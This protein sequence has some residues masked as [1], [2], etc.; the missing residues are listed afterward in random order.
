MRRRLPLEGLRALT[1]EDR[2]LRLGRPWTIDVILVEVE[3]EQFFAEEAPT[4]GYNSG[5]KEGRFHSKS[6]V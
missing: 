5:L 1:Q 3:D 6:M 4:S 2:G